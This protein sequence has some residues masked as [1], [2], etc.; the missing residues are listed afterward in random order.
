VLGRALRHPKRRALPDTSPE[1]KR[2]KRAC[3]HVTKRKLLTLFELIFARYEGHNANPLE[4]R[5][6]F[7]SAQLKPV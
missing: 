4:I 3:V 1:G 5:F 2:I 6:G 7:P